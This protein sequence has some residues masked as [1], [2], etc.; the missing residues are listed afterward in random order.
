MCESL[1]GSPAIARERGDGEAIFV[2]CPS[3][4]DDHRV[5]SMRA[6]PACPGIPMTS[7]IPQ[8]LGLG[9][10]RIHPIRFRGLR[11]QRWQETVRK[12]L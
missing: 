1:R 8:L 3:D 2:V 6:C 5:G 9:D 7:L 11:E 10:R 4:R 12:A